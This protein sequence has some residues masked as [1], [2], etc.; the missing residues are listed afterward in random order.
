MECPY[1]TAAT[2]IELISYSLVYYCCSYY[3]CCLFLISIY[4][5]IDHYYRIYCYCYYYCY[6]YCYCWYWR[7]VLFCFC[8]WFSGLVTVMLFYCGW[9]CLLYCLC[10]LLTCLTHYYYYGYYYGYY[11][12]CWDVLFSYLPTA[13]YFAF[14]YECWYYGW[15]WSKYYHQFYPTPAWSYTP[16]IS[17]PFPD[18]AH[19]IYIPSYP[20]IR[21]SQEIAN[22]SIV[23]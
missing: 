9:G 14:Y 1:V 7:W 22:N 23:I 17:L 3:C 18:T 21:N 5:G 12:C 19:A 20:V 15:A 4:A 13:H 11:G 10:V 6:C 16:A 8:F 2:Y